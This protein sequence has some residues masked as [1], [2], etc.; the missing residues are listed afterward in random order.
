M[1]IFECLVRMGHAGAGRSWDR[2]VRVRADNALEAMRRA[3]GLPGVKKGHALTSGN[4]VLS[5]AM[6]R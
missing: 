5:V 1:Y 6:V 3:K 4:S 2:V